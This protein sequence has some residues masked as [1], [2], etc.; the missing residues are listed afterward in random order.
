VSR[1][2]EAQHFAV[3][4]G[5]KP[6]LNAYAK[7]GWCFVASKLD[8][9]SGTNAFF[10]PQPLV[11][12]FKTDR[13]VYPLRLT[14]PGNSRVEIDLYVF[15][16]SRAEVPGF[17]VKWCRQANYLRDSNPL[18]SE[19]SFWHPSICQ[20][21]QN[22]PV[23]THLS[24][25]LHSRDMQTDAWV[26][27]GSFQPASDIRYSPRDARRMAVCLFFVI[28][29]GILILIRMSQWLREARALRMIRWCKYGMIAGLIASVLFY[30]S[31]PT[32]PVRELRTR[33]VRSIPNLM[34]GW[35]QQLAMEVKD[36]VSESAGKAIPEVIQKGR[37]AIHDYLELCRRGGV[38]VDNPV[39]GQ[40]FREE[41][42]PG[43]YIFRAGSNSLDCVFYDME[44]R[45]ILYQIY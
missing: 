3:S 32:V 13:A 25:V 20:L 9:T 35:H 18:N 38:M 44:G 37:V 23:A 7:E 16:M 10:R 11:L 14:G 43:N 8:V 21:A 6:V 28:L 2:L 17:K 1:W 33:W 40:P 26:D 34:R 42:S 30:W 5:W 4:D 29:G 41:D 45:E 27:W 12:T 19:F 15:G 22:L 39:T 31:I 36:T 24:G